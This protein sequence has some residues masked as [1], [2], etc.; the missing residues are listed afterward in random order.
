MPWAE[1]NVFSGSNRK[2]LAFAYIEKVK[3][4]ICRFVLSSI[5][6]K[7]FRT[8][9]IEG[10]NP[11]LAHQPPLFSPI[12]YLLIMSFSF[13]LLP[14]GMGSAQET[15]IPVVYLNEEQKG[16]FFIKMTDDR[17]FLVKVE[18][19]KEIGLQDPKG[20]ARIIEGSSFISLQS[21][22]GLKFE[23]DPNRQ[24]LKIQAPPEMLARKVL[25]LAAKQP[26]N[27]QSP[28]DNSL[29]FNYG[30]SYNAV[31]G[32][33][34]DSIG[35][36]GQL[37]VRM[38]N[39]LFLSDSV[40]NIGDTESRVNRLLTSITYDRRQGM[41]SFILGDTHATSG[42]LGSSLFLG[43]FSY[44]KNYSADPNVIKRPVQGYQGYATTP[45]EINVYLNGVK[46]GSEKVSPGGFDIRNI[47]AYGG[48]QDLEIV[49]KDAFGRE[50]RITNPFYVSDSLLAKGFHD[51][52][53]HIGFIRE[54]IGTPQDQYGDPAFLGFHRYGLTDFLTVGLRGEVGKGIH[55]FGGGISFVT[56]FGAMEMAWAGSR[57]KEEK[58]GTAYSLN[59]SF[60]SGAFNAR[61]GTTS[62]SEDF[63]T[64]SSESSKNPSAL[65]K[66]QLEFGAGIGFGTKKFGSMAVN[67]SKSTQYGDSEKNQWGFMYSKGIGQ[68]FNV[69]LS[70]Y[71]SHEKGPEVDKSDIE[72]FV[73][74]TY[75]PW[76]ETIMT[77]TGMSGESFR[78]NFQLQKNAPIGEGYGYRA[79]VDMREEKEGMV[80]NFR[81]YF[82][83]N[84]KYGIYSTQLSA[85]IGGSDNL[86][87]YQ[88]N[89]SGAIVYVGKTFGFSRP[90]D[91][92][93]ALVRVGEVPGVRV[94]HNNQEIGKTD[95]SG[96]MVLPNFHSYDNNQ[97][98]INDK[99]IPLSFALKDVSRLISPGYR[100]GTLIEFEAKKVQAYTALLKGIKDGKKFP[101]EYHSIIMKLNGKTI[102]FQTGRDGEFF[103]EDARAG[104]FKAQ[105]KYAGKIFLF[106]ISIPKSEDIII[107][108]GEIDVKVD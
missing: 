28:L 55:N 72:F 36:T 70:L 3:E 1:H 48:R 96:K 45:S 51:Y 52:S 85:Q 81:P 63:S 98:R 32:F 49:I 68:R 40:I 47:I 92:S 50:Q 58:T 78:G 77:N 54:N 83:Y 10:K 66:P 106:N 29:F 25:N 14:P 64:L 88:F 24:T 13:L 7:C 34:F 23:F 19:L 89:A 30:I 21:L 41:E 69:T 71:Q 103:I 15:I 26:K 8:G 6:W 108:G 22:P 107:D 105:L 100:S 18:D 90:V 73:S 4:Q 61:I 101:I 99:D 35:L 37:G 39:F 79:S 42:S 94:Y 9:F 104:D 38:G 67:Y 95:R 5:C 31:K 56:R 43:G 20:K 27:V 102:T 80:T 84:G 76:K 75:Y 46:V 16:E 86:Q 33:R 44:I 12:L 93:F 74:L 87:T 17:D 62:Y 82:Q 91:D 57:N 65:Q 60:Q 2:V 53:Y 97:I 59:Y 11:V